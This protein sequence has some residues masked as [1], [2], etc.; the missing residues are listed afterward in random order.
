[1][2]QEALSVWAN[3]AGWLA[4]LFGSLGPDTQQQLGTLCFGWQLPES[5]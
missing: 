2:S 1:M 4:I 3:L 5:H